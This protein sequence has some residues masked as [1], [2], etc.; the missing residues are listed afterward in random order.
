MIRISGD[1]ILMRRRMAPGGDDGSS[2]QGDGTMKE[3]ETKNW[4]GVSKAKFLAFGGMRAGGGSE[5]AEYIRVDQ[6]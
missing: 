3:R 2:R 5:V 1:L 6:V 4:F